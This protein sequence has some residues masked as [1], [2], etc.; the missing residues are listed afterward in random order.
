[1]EKLPFLALN[2][3]IQQRESVP[4]E[5]ELDLLVQRAVCSKRRKVVDFNQPGL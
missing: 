2:R 3:Q 1:M 5:V 4:N